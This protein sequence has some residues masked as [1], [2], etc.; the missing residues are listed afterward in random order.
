[1]LPG[2]K[3][4]RRVGRGLGVPWR[5]TRRAEDWSPNG[6]AVYGA[7][8]GEDVGEGRAR[9]E[10]WNKALPV[11]IG[12]KATA[13]IAA[14]PVTFS[15]RRTLTRSTIPPSPER[16]MTSCLI[17]SLARGR[18]TWRANCEI[19]S[20]LSVRW[21]WYGGVLSSSRSGFKAS[22]KKASAFCVPENVEMTTCILG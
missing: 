9:H 17:P 13:G 10:L 18:M 16:R 6:W 12:I 1:M 7:L 22:S 20:G 8:V 3:V 15:S 19:V 4:T 5:R 21:T 11:P 2:E 14:S